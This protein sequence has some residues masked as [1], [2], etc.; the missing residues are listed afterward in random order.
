MFVPADKR[1]WGY[2]VFPILE[3][4][5][6]V[7][8]I[9]VTASRQASTLNVVNFWPEAG[10]QWP[11][12]RFQKLHAELSRMARFVGLKEIAWYCQIGA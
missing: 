8:R 10:V 12:N 2:Y 1:V 4:H 9:E 6:F 3:G 11:A 5:R 7:G